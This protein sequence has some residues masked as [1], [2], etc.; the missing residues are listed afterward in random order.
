MRNKFAGILISLVA[1]LSVI[2]G[3]MVVSA[4]DD[5]QPYLGIT[6]QPADEG[7]EVLRVL[8][9]S[10][11]ADAGL[12]RGDIIT[13]INDEAVSADTVADAIGALSVGDE[14]LMDVLRGDETLELTATLAEQPAR[15]ML[16]VM[17]QVRMIQRAYL[18]VSLEAVD[19]GVRIAAVSAGSPAAEAGLQVDDVI[20]AVNGEAVSEPAEVTAAVRELEPGAVVTLSILRGGEAQDIEVTV[21]SMADHMPAIMGEVIIYDG[22]NW[23]IISLREDSALAAAGLQAGDVITAINGESYDPAA[24]DEFLS[25]LADDATVTL[26]VE[27]AGETVEVTV[28]AADLQALD[29]FGFGGMFR[30]QDGERGPRFEFRGPRGQFEFFPGGVRLGVQVED[31]ADGAVITDVLED[32]PAAEAGLQV[33]DVIVA[34]NGD[35]V[36]AERTLR[37]RLLAYDPGD[38]V[39]LEVQRGDET[40]TID[41]TLAEVDVQSFLDELPFEFDGE[42]PRFFFG[43]NDPVQPAA[44]AAN[45]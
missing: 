42:F 43:P 1:V 18:G 23:Q 32:T 7:V 5:V 44:P 6:F 36:D 39:T 30:G 13:A 12:Q 33:D 3:V 41:V 10:P 16:R 24:L 27:R 26:S 35:T 25:G 19:E 45:L 40:L 17:P 29:A 38:M 4:Q 15:P 37:E 11:A 2:A 34:V 14:I 8:R 31:T 20:T 22:E 21:G 9:N 28:N